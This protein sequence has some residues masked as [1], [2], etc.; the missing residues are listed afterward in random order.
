MIALL[1][2]ILPNLGLPSI[3]SSRQNFVHISNPSININ[4]QILDIY[5]FLIGSSIETSLHEI[6]AFIIRDDAKLQ[7]CAFLLEIFIRRIS[8]SKKCVLPVEINWINLFL[9]N[10]NIH[11]K[12]NYSSVIFFK[13]IVLIYSV[14]DFPANYSRIL[15]IQSNPSDNISNFIFLQELIE[16]SRVHIQ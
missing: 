2:L 3:F 13:F 7:N 5:I 1:I 8:R 14:F 10:H 15:T 11:S 4:T 12:H 6:Y 9:L 16:I